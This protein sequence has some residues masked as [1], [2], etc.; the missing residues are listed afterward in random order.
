M[1]I[2]AA[3]VRR[4]YGEQATPAEQQGPVQISGQNT[5]RRW[6][7]VSMATEGPAPKHIMR[8]HGNLFRYITTP[9]NIYQAYRLARRGK[10]RL[11]S[12]LRFEKDEEN[13]LDEIRRSL[14]EKTFTT[15]AY[16]EKMVYEPKQRTIYILPFAPDRIVQHALMNVLTPIW[17]PMFIK[18]S[19]A[20]MQGRG[21]H[22]GSRR[23]MEFVR[24]NTF[25]LKCDVSKFYP[26]VDHSILLS[27][28]KRKIKCP[29]TLWLLENIISSFPG[30]KNV[31][32]GN[33]TS[34]WF[35]NLYLNELDRFVKDE[36]KVADYVR[37]C[38][39]FLLF[40]NDKVRLRSAA[41]AV[42]SFCA[43]RLALRLS[44]CDLFPVSRGVDFLGYRHFPRYILLRKRTARRMAKRL[45]ALPELLATGQISPENAR[46]VVASAQGWMQWANTHHFKLAVHMDDLV[47][48]T[49][50]AC[51]NGASQKIL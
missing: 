20:C 30:G 12:I 8:R 38:D 22:V 44:K 6:C 51:K 27:I 7:R 13:R 39:D 16:N 48:L 45:K 41:A 21:I 33:Y 49:N 40:G 50:G 10:P 32:I 18:D 4:G 47:C 35:G 11:E 37:Y 25:C 23:T 34:Q 36:L 17:E 1:R 29:D 42:T 31:P 5:Q 28:I 15:S 2:T 9:E 43:N 14:A 19:Y 24:R 26:S 3:R 46:S